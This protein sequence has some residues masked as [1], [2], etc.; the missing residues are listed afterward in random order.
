MHLPIK[1]GHTVGP[2]TFSPHVPLTTQTSFRKKHLAHRAHHLAHR[3]LA[4]R[5]VGTSN[6]SWRYGKV[7][8]TMPY[9]HNPAP[10]PRNPAVRAHITSTIVPRTATFQH[11]VQDVSLQVDGPANYRPQMVPLATRINNGH[12]VSQY[13]QQ[14]QQR[15]HS[16][17]HQSVQVRPTNQPINTAAPHVPS[18]QRKP[19]TASAVTTLLPYCTAKVPLNEGQVIAVT[20]AAGSL[21][22]L[23]LLALGAKDG[24]EERLSRLESAL[25]SEQT[26]ADVV[27]FFSDEFEIE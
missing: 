1:R 24:D 19:A 10:V 7:N 16:H 6:I 3:S 27:D 14:Q 18:K 22:E 12:P 21:K 13:Q 5:R 4:Q 15:S 23:V 17:Q 9:C 8:N 25:G 11:S 26:T 20:D 2:A